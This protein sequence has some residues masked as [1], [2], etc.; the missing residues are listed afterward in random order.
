[1]D[2]GSV[3][4]KQINLLQ[5]VRNITSSVIVSIG[6]LVFDNKAVIFD[7]EENVIAFL[8]NDVLFKLHILLLVMLYIAVY[9]HLIDLGEKALG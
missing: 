2:H 8:E 5:A 1:M 9:V 3:V 7:I 6:R 4:G